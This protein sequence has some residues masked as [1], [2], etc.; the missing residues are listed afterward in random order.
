MSSVEDAFKTP[1]PPDIRASPGLNGAQRTYIRPQ[2]QSLFYQ[3]MV[4]S[5]HSLRI[6]LSHHREA[7]AI[8]GTLVSEGP[9]LGSFA[10]AFFF[11]PS[12]AL[13]VAL[14]RGLLPSALNDSAV[15]PSFRAAGPEPAGSWGWGCRCSSPH[16][17]TGPITGGHSFSVLGLWTVTDF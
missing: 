7:P 8:G 10:V 9:S 2:T 12:F 6:W 1:S 3:E 14:A 15:C 16:A 4:K 17:P 5:P 13:L 11:S